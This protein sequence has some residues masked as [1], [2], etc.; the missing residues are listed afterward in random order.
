M[1]NEFTIVTSMRYS[2]GN[3]SQVLKDQY[4]ADQTSSP[5]GG[6]PGVQDV[7]TTHEALEVP[8]LTNLGVAYFKNLDETNFVEIG[9]DVS[10]TFYPLVR[11]L[12]GEST[13]FRFATTS[14]PYL[15]ADTAA[16]R[17]QGAVYED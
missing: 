2:S 6:A 17:V 3:D 1:A 10:A 12:P 15:R 14:T 5:L 13:V 7:G 16:V 4:T 8:G 11:L 9:V